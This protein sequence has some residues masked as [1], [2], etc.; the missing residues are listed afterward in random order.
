MA[1]TRGENDPDLP[2]LVPCRTFPEE[3]RC[4]IRL[5]LCDL[6]LE[7][8]RALPD[9]RAYFP[10]YLLTNERGVHYYAIAWDTGLC[11]QSAPFLAADSILL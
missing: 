10:P 5:I 4:Y 2:H 11:R 3:R 6:S 9:S 1:L 7:E 8:K